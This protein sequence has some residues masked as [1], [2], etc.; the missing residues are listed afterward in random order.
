MSD[1]GTMLADT[2]ERLFAAHAETLADANG[3]WPAATWAAIEE[4]GLP[5]ALVPEDSGGFGVPVPEALALIRQTGRHALPLPLAETIMANAALAA[6]GLPLAEG[7]AAL[8]PAGDQR[9]AWGRFATT[10][11]HD[12]DGARHRT[13]QLACTATNTNLAGMPRDT[14]ALEG[15]AEGSMSSNG[16]T[17]LELGALARAL[18]MAGAL[19][20]VLELTI[21][22]VSTRVQFGRPLAKFQAIQQEIAK[23]AG[24]VASASAAADHAAD[25]YADGGDLSF[26]I[27]VARTRIGE[28]ASKATAIAHQLHG[29]IG[30]TREHALHRLTTALWSWRDEFGTQRHWTLLLG[31]RALDAGPTNYWPMVVA[32]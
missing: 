5:L 19:D 21:D 18:Q 11:V 13:G 7:P 12:A 3:A 26:A 6:A 29:A 4:S 16:P 27:A 14:L 25:T 10:L 28:A 32:A 15:S 30:F 24:E 9:I 17:L 20:R 1:I 23:L 31:K 22:H 2:A 8:V